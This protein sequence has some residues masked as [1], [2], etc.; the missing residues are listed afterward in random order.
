[1]KSSFKRLVLTVIMFLTAGIISAQKADTVYLTSLDITQIQQGWGEPQKN[2]SVDGNPITIGGQTFKNGV[3]THAKSIFKINLARGSERFLAYAGVDTEIGKNKTGTVNYE[4]TGDGRT[5]W[6]S[7]VLKAGMQPVKVDVDLK[8]IKQLVLIINDGGDDI[9]YDHADWADAKFI[10]KGKMPKAVTVPVEKPYILTPKESPKPKI[11]GA[12]VYGVRPG[13]PFLYYIPA[14][15]KRPMEYAVENLPAGLALDNK[16]GIITGK[17]EREGEYFVKFIAKNSLGQA[18]KKFKIICGNKIALTPPLGWNSWNCFAGDVTADKI[19]AAADAMV[20]SGLINHGWTYINIDDCW[21]VKPG[22]D[23]PM[24]SGEIRDKNGMIQANKK[25]PDMK[26]L[27]DYVHSNG[28]KIGLYSSPGSLTC[29]GFT[30]S[31]KYEKEDAIQFAAWGY[32]YLKYDWCSY[33]RVAKDNSLPELQKPYAIMRKALDGVKRDIVFSLCQ[34]G[35][36]KV[37]EWGEE[38][39]G[40]CWRTTGDITDTWNSVE[41]IGF[42]QAGKEKYAGPGHWNDPDMLVVGKVGWGPQLHNTRLTPS[43]QYTHITLWSLLA[44]PLLI[45]CDMTQLDPFTLNLLTN[46]EV[47]AVNQDA[48][49]KQAARVYQNGYIEVWTKELEDGSVAAGIFN[50]G[51]E[52]AKVSVKLADLNL[53]GKF[54][55][56]DLWRQKN[57]GS[58]DKEYKCLIP[59]HGAV[60]IKLTKLK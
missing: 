45:G 19:K 12:G 49:G 43:E 36:G 25:F 48:L 26:G 35:M 9:N 10:V 15:G 23:D 22:S 30:G 54:A 33:S 29:A 41:N 16:T 14:T 40:N 60:L 55:V 57:T 47:I 2:L 11:N 38:I 46:D 5:L 17:I 20:K 7:E 42:S 21:M 37:W 44:S 39:G 53:K 59:R 34:Y 50:R 3:G 18:E 56:R 8:G 27:A 51:E 6:K 4:I 1:M 52:Q 31:Y 32:D 28:L 24:L 13:N 58:I